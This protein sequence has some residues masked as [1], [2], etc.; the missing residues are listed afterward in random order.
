MTILHASPE[1][2]GKLML[3]RPGVM[4]LLVIK[5]FSSSLPLI[6][7]L[8]TI[9]TTEYVISPTINCYSFDDIAMTIIRQ[10][11]FSIWQSQVRLFLIIQILEK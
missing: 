3:E 5:L 9:F 7:T 2:C 4:D 11:S 1:T 6:K 8:P 10:R